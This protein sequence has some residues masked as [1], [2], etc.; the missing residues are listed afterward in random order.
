M[1]SQLVQKN[2]NT[3]ILDS[4]NANPSSMKAAIENMAAMK[5]TNKVLILGDMFEL[6]EEA[7]NEH[8]AI[9]KMLRDLPFTKICCAEN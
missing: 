6:E 1:R 9:G 8:R 3:I 7:E 2:G 5:A 4:Y